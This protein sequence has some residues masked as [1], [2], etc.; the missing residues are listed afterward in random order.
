MRSS[1]ASVV[2][3]TW[4]G[5]K[6]VIRACSRRSKTAFFIPGDV[7]GS[8]C[9]RPAPTLRPGN[10]ISRNQ[11]ALKLAFLC[12]LGERLTKLQNHK[13]DEPQARHW[14]LR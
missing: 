11:P 13:R 12:D 10:H 4:R 5:D 8:S 7:P 9:L 1:V 2:Q 6:P 14:T 3:E